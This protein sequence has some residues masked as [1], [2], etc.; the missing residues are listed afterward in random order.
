MPDVGHVGVVGCGPVGAVLALALCCKG[1]K[2]T[3]IEA[4]DGPVEDQR[5]A[6]VHPP[7]V[8]MLV[9]LGLKDAAWDGDAG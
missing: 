1:I 8:E 5:A 3:I 2:V 6:T 4:N 7:T 9:G